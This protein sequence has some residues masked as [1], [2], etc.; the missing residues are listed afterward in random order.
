MISGASEHGG[1]LQR[2]K[3]IDI[4]SYRRWWVFMSSSNRLV[5]AALRMMLSLVILVASLSENMCG[6]ALATFAASQTPSK[7]HI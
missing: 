5:M 1:Y 2:S 6:I 3:K 7:T 4:P